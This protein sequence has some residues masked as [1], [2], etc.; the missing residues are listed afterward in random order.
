MTRRANGHVCA[1]QLTVITPGFYELEAV[2][3]SIS[4]TNIGQNRPTQTVAHDFQRTRAGYRTWKP[5]TSSMKDPGRFGTD[6]IGNVRLCFLEI[7]SVPRCLTQMVK[8]WLCMF[9]CTNNIFTKPQC[10]QV[11]CCGGAMNCQKLAIM[12]HTLEKG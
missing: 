9:R 1:L 7:I 6:D 4:H 5:Y 3:R 11:P 8:L 12:C 2:R 10:M